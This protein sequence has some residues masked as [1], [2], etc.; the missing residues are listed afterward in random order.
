MDI[1]MI[2]EIEFQNQNWRKAHR[3]VLNDFSD[4]ECRQKFRLPLRKI[5]EIVNT[6][7]DDLSSTTGQNNSIL[8]ETKVLVSLRFLAT[9][10]FQNPIGDTSEM[11]QASTSR[12][13]HQFC[14]S[15]MQH[16]SYLVKWYSSQEE[17]TKVKQSYFEACGVKGLLGLIDGTMVPIKGVTGA[18]EPAFICRKGYS[19]INCQFVVD[20]DGQFRDVV[21]KYPGSCHDA[22]VYSN[23]TLK[24]TMEADPVA[25][26]LFGD[27]GYG[28]SPVMITPFSPAITP[29]EMFF[30][31]T[32]SRVRSR[33]ERCIGSLKNRWRCLHK[34]GGT[35]QYSPTKCCSIIYT[36][37]LLENMCNSLG[38]EEPDNVVA[39]D[40][41]V[42]NTEMI[43][44]NSST[45]NNS[46]FYHVGRRQINQIRLGLTRRNDLK[47][48]MFA[49]R[50]PHVL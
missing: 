24:Q 50:H 29:E 12:I 11:S 36:C 21:I 15:F 2:Q 16:Y 19:A 20:Y 32:H 30:N 6:L 33:I 41:A 45:E 42:G 23:S 47:N 31:K 34:S 43:T 28:L 14:E 13:I 4:V 10:S 40:D 26:F 25:G 49:N 27:S 9:G 7:Q 18:D 46:N 35:L 3:A 5:S 44:D 1:Q 37:V 22:F 48:Y 8:P 17:I 38:L 39:S